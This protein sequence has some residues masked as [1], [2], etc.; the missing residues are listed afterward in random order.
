MLYSMTGFGKST[1]QLP[2][3]KITI[4]IKSLNSKQLDLNSRVPSA[5]REAE[6]TWRNILAAKLQ[7]GKVDLSVTVENLG[8]SELSHLNNDA[9]AA[10]KRQIEDSALKLGIDVPADWFSILMRFPDVMVSDKD[11]QID[12]EELA[13]VRAA[14]ESAADALME[15]RRAEGIKLEEFFAVRIAR[16]TELL[17]EI[18][19]FEQER[20]A[21]IKERLADS[22]SKIPAVEYDKGRLEQEMIFY[23]EKL[24]VNEERQRLAQH[25]TYFTETMN[26]PA[27]GQGK[28]LGFIAQEMGREIN[29]LGSK[30]NHAEM[31]RIVV[32][33]KDEL[34]QIKEQVLNVM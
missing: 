14:I 25:L 18:P 15:Y 28:K 13:S 24:D 10:Y 1:C 29:T 2:S 19:Q 6:L 7:R 26:L 33:M 4:E 16:I 21:R 20:T 27:A 3:K 5:Y 9:L 17:A 30:S 23:I 31:Q 11:T 34:E 32:M 8:E 22:L 12:P